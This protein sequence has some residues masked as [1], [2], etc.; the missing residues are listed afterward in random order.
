MRIA[1]TRHVAATRVAAS[2]SGRLPSPSAVRRRRVRVVGHLASV[3][4]NRER[5]DG[6]GAEEGRRQ[7]LPERHTLARVGMQQCRA[8]GD[9]TE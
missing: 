7:Q 5:I 1:A 6:V 8:A 2:G 3:S 9:Q 4:I